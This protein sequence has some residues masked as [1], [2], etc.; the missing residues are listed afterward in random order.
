MTG[1]ELTDEGVMAEVRALPEPTRARVL[2][3]LD[4]SHMPAGAR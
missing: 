2:A 1:T 3:Y 4:Q